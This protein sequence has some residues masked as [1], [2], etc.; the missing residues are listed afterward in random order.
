MG[1]KRGEELANVRSYKGIDTGGFGLGYWGNEKGSY[2][3]LMC[4][5]WGLLVV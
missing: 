5:I 1:G 3:I 2:T 4:H